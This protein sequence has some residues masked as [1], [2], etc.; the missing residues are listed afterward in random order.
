M[1]V[2]NVWK[3]NSEEQFLLATHTEF[4]LLTCHLWS[5]HSSDSYIF[6]CKEYPFKGSFWSSSERDFGEFERYYRLP[7]L[8]TKACCYH[9]MRSQLDGFNTTVTPFACGFFCFL[10][11]FVLVFCAVAT[12]LRWCY[13]LYLFSV[14]LCY[15]IE[16]WL[17]M[18]GITTCA[19]GDRLQNK[20]PALYTSNYMIDPAEKTLD[21]FDSSGSAAS[22]FLLWFCCY[23]FPDM[24]FCCCF[25]ITFLLRT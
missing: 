18:E 8:S 21:S 12:L 22:D 11:G 1:V 13:V 17:C 6:I 15:F 7:S 24:V 14:T 3:W 23:G 4:L 16:R 20:T 9:K 19:K 5:R 10:F 25:T 2:P